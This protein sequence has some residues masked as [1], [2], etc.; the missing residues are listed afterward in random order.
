M[1]D[2]FIATEADGSQWVSLENYNVLKKFFD[3]VAETLKYVEESMSIED[4]LFWL[5]KDIETTVQAAQHSDPTLESGRVLPVE[6][7]NSEGSAPAI[8][9]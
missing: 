7:T 5:R 3:D 1:N 2:I 9:G 4:V 6:S 8:S